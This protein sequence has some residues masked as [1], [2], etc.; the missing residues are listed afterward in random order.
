[1]RSDAVS[2]TG[3]GDGNVGCEFSDMPQPQFVPQQHEVPIASRVESFAS[4]QQLEDRLPVSVVGQQELGASESA[5]L[6]ANPAWAGSL[7][8]G[9]QLPVDS[10]MPPK[11]LAKALD[12]QA[13][14]GIG[15]DWANNITTANH[16][17]RR[18][19]IGLD[20]VASIESTFLGCE[21]MT[22]FDVRRLLSTKKQGNL[23]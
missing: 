8:V 14:L 19:T 3:T 17:A 16:A 22:S 6:V 1:M 15:N 12:A 9:Q 7:V 13:Q 20:V 21:K 2:S 11:W 4:P 5:L 18:E 23:K 10:L